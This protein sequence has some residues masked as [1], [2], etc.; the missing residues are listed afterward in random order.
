MYEL[1]EGQIYQCPVCG[2]EI[3]ILKDAEPVAPLSCCGVEMEL[4]A[5]PMAGE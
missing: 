5:S 1:K 2:V 3:R 4:I